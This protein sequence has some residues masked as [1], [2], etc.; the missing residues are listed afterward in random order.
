MSKDSGPT[1][2]ELANSASS[3]SGVMLKNAATGKCADI[4]NYGSG[5]INGPVN[6]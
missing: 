3:Q 4:P 2:R 6:Q 1:A 5:A